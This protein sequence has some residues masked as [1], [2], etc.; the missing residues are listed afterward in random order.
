LS[1][2]D[3]VSD[4]IVLAAWSPVYIGKEAGANGNKLIVEGKLMGTIIVGADGNVGNELVLEA[5]AELNAV[6][7]NLYAGNF[8]RI[9]EELFGRTAAEVE[10][11]DLLSLNGTAYLRVGETT[12]SSTNLET[13]GLVLVPDSV[14]G[15]VVVS[16]APV[17]EPSTYALIGAVG[18]AALALL[19]RRKRK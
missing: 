14:P 3:D 5:S 4:S 16:V 10:I 18:A 13:S 17:P 8:L 7:I 15:Y 1:K 19:R 12:V 11:S 6:D 9:A 2:T